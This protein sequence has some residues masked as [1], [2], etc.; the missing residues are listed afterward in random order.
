[1]TEEEKKYVYNPYQQS[2]SVTQAQ[3]AL[4]TQQ[5]AKP[6]Q[7]QGQW[8]SQLNDLMG[9][10]QNRPAFQYDVNADALWNQY[11]DQ[12]VNQGRQA[13]M[14]TMGQAAAM[15]GGYGN[16]YAQTVGQQAYQ[17]YLQGVN[18]KLPDLY[19]LAMN[20]YQTE[21]DQ[22]LTQYGLMADQESQEYSRYMDAVNQYYADLDRAQSLYDAERNFDYGK[23]ADDRNFDYSQYRD[24]M[25]DWQWQ[26]QW[27]E[28]VRRYN[29]EHGLGEFA[30]AG[31]GEE[32]GGSSG[33][34]ISFIDEAT[35]AAQ[36]HNGVDKEVYAYINSQPVSEAEKHAALDNAKGVAMTNRYQN[37]LNSDGYRERWQR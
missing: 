32:S 19:Q 8:Q 30:S 29:Y 31:G 7:Y 20:R 21:G 17:G 13:M 11:K 28:N 22:L 14:D 18:D 1:M 37:L 4:K 2:D 3:D 36:L 26:T 6:A 10:I 23:W 9:Q 12:Y 15:T 24:Q 25:A 33:G 27:D 34:T 16:S 5:S 35:K